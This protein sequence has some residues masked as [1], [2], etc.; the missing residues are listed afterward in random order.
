[1]KKEYRQPL[2]ELIFTESRDIL[3][4]SGDIDVD[5]SEILDSAAFTVRGTLNDGKFGA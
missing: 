4:A 2:V 5:P 3:L 1:M